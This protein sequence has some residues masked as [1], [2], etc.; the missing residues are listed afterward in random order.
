VAFAALGLE[1]SSELNYSIPVHLAGQK[2]NLDE[3]EEF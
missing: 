2:I 1:G 3:K